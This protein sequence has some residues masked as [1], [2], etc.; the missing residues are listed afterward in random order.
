MIELKPCPF[1]A[2]IQN[3]PCFSLLNFND[4][5]YLKLKCDFCSCSLE[6]HISESRYFHLSTISLD[7]LKLQLIYKWN[8]REG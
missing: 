8:K 7:C 4:N 2:G 1:C 3:E 6:K 5:I